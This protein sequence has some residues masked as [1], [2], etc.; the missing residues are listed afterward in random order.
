MDPKSGFPHVLIVE[1]TPGILTFYIDIFIIHIEP[2]CLLASFL[3]SFLLP[4]AYFLSSYFS[5]IAAS[6]YILSFRIKTKEVLYF[7]R[8]KI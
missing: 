4:I 2:A 6:S 8:K 5:N 3:P 7:T 1:L